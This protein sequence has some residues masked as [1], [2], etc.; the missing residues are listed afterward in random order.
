MQAYFTR[1]PH[2]ATVIEIFIL[3][4]AILGMAR[5]P[6]KRRRFTLRR[7]RISNEVVMGTLG[8]DTAITGSLTGATVNGYRMVTAKLTWS[9]MGGT[10]GQG[11]VTVGFAHSDYSVAE[12]KA[13]LESFASIDQ[14]DKIAQELSNRLVRIVGTISMGGG[15]MNILNNGLPI[16]TKLNWKIG[17][18]DSVNIF[19]FNENVAPLTTGT[20]LNTQGN[21]WVRDT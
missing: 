18:G 20:V 16:S 9:I 21:L 8:S 2:S 1:R 19:A 11:P 13:C 5:K 12:I 4:V 6:T 14:G 15:N 17:I 7:V 3:L 10:T